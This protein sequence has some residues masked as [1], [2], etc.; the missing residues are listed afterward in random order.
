MASLFS[1]DSNGLTQGRGISMRRFVAFLGICVVTMLAPSATVSADSRVIEMRPVS[2]NLGL[3]SWA[4]PLVKEFQAVKSTPALVGDPTNVTS[5]MMHTF[6]QVDFVLPGSDGPFKFSRRYYST[7]EYEGPIG[8]G[9]T[10]CLNCTI[11]RRNDSMFEVMDPEGM[12][13]FFAKLPGASTFVPLNETASKLVRWTENA[14]DPKPIYKMAWITEDGIK[15]IFPDV[16]RA[17][18]HFPRYVAAIEY[19]EG[20]TLS[21][22]PGN[23]SLPTEITASS[24]WKIRLSYSNRLLTDIYEPG[25]PDDKPIHFEYE[26]G[27]LISVTYPVDPTT[28]RVRRYF[29]EDP[30][31]RHNLTRIMFERGDSFYYVYDAMDRCIDSHGEEVAGGG[32]PYFNHIFE[33]Y[34]DERKTIVTRV[35]G[36]ER[37]TDVYYYN[38]RDYIVRLDHVDSGITKKYSY[39]I[40][41]GS[42]ATVEKEIMNLSKDEYYKRALFLDEKYDIIGMMEDMK[43]GGFEPNVRQPVEPTGQDRDYSKY[44]TPIAYLTFRSADFTYNVLDR[45]AT[46]YTCN[47]TSTDTSCEVM[48]FNYNP[49]GTL[50]EVRD[51]KERRATYSYDKEG[52]LI[53]VEPAGMPHPFMY[54]MSTLSIGPSFENKHYEGAFLDMVEERDW[55]GRVTKITYLL[56]EGNILTEQYDYNAADLHDADAKY[57]VNFFAADGRKTQYLYDNAGLLWKVIED[58][59]EGRMNA[60]TTFQHDSFGNLISFSDPNGRTTTCTYDSLRRLISIRRPALP[61]MPAGYKTASLRIRAAL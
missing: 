7:S 51:S 42:A 13:N 26:N 18:M 53:D 28:T 31:D 2:W 16:M 25:R 3:P 52:K 20:K 46:I 58:M 24:G 21:F 17:V 22:S 12:F 27:N 59:G 50:Q 41:Q 60:V 30:N 40:V 6:P 36:G 47:D 33:Y 1:T 45:V 49:D 57:G 8:Y 56:Q 11:T 43:G 10:H 15:Y 48:M 34:P 5:G 19:G 38:S 35:Q 44:P 39:D 9:W 4:T 37:F 32:G 29:Y 61:A 55:L 54:S 23:G 14:N